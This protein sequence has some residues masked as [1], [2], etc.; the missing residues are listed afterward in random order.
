MDKIRILKNSKQYPS[1]KVEKKVQ[2]INNN[3]L[4]DNYFTKPAEE[5]GKC[6]GSAKRGNVTLSES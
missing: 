5:I 1:E 4:I 2:I 6:R 3:R